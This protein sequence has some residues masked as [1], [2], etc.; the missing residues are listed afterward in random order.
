MNVQHE[1]AFNKILIALKLYKF[2]LTLTYLKIYRQTNLC[3]KLVNGTDQENMDW[4]H[5]WLNII[6]L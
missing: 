6:N 2:L 1:Q 4:F 3:A 5:K